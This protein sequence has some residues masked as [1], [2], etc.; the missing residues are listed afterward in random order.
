MNTYTYKIKVSCNWSSSEEVTKRLLTQFKTSDK[1]IE[2][3]EFVHGD[4]YDLHVVFGYIND[5]IIDDK[6]TFVFPQEPTWTGGHQKG[7]I[8]INNI[9][10]F[11]FSNHH[12][13][14]MD[15][16]VETV[17]H[18]FYGGRGPWEEGFDFWNYDNLTTNEFNKSKGFCSFISNRGKEDTSH[19][20]GCT[21]GDRVSLVTN[22]HKKTPYIDFYGWGDSD[23]F[24]PFA[25]KKGESIKDYKF[26]LTIENSSEKYYIS[27]KFYDCILTN[28]IP[29]YHG[30]TNIKEYWNENG[31]FLLDNITD[32]QYVID[33]LNWINENRDELYKQMLPEL[34]KMKKRYFE[35]FNLLKKIRKEYYEL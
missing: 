1:D 8:G 14:P 18:M 7:F 12:Y 11:G 34:L 22:I 32:H 30:C 25:R 28:T 35:E 23:N 16:V 24:K 13:H 31:Y 20:L 19:P 15:I 9:K 33:K 26:C 10:V 17:A 5:K 4:D 2:N 3:F 29:I 21:Y 6:P 27:E